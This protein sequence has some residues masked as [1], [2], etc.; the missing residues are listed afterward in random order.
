MLDP[1][2]P[3]H[4]QGQGSSHPPFSHPF[5]HSARIPYTAGRLHLGVGHRPVPGV[6]VTVTLRLEQN[7]L[8][9]AQV[10]GS[11][12]KT[13]K[14]TKCKNYIGPQNW[15][16]CLGPA[17]SPTPRATRSLGSVPLFLRPLF[18][19][20]LSSASRGVLALTLDHLPGGQKMDIACQFLGNHIQRKEGGCFRASLSRS[21]RC[22]L[23]SPTAHWQK[24]MT[25]ALLNQPLRGQQHH[26]NLPQTYHLYLAFKTLQ[27]L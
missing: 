22:F 2:F 19:P 23:G 1:A 5:L 4:L 15:G 11:L 10:K 18:F 3:H 16:W 9:P 17:C 6:L 26:G 7:P 14:D 24:C 13:L 21:L 8:K 12:R 20:F 27:D 25:R